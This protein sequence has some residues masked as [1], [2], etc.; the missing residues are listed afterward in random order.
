MADAA[1][2]VP[3]VFGEA[4]IR[5]LL[6]LEVR[7]STRY[8]DFLS[9]WLVQAVYPGERRGDLDAAVARRIAEIL[10]A[11]DI[12]GLLDPEILVLLVHT[13]EAD[14]RVIVDRV[15]DQVEG[16]VFELAPRPGRVSLRI[17]RASFPTDATNEGGLL[18]HAQSRLEPAPPSSD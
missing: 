13:P 17:G 18:A 9:V 7:R 10:R 11:T 1:G 12:V 8:Q 16:E 15:R 6:S 14:S 3:R 4:E 2:A 5:H